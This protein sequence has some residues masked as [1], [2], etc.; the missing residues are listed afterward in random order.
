MILIALAYLLL[1]LRVRIGLNLSVSGTSG[2][3]MLIAGAAG[4]CLRFDGEIHRESGRLLLTLRPRYGKLSREKRPKEES[5]RALRIARWYLWFAR[6]GRMERLA[7]DA[8]VGLGDAAQTALAAGCLRALAAAA[9][10]RLESEAAY[11]LRVTPD[12]GCACFCAQ[13]RCIFSCQPGDI[14]LAAIR[15]GKSRREGLGWKSIP[16]RA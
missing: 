15:A 4:F 6:T 13:A 7:L 9:F 14:M 3:L 2:S 10:S 8:R 12:F 16:L 5:G 1:A 11:E